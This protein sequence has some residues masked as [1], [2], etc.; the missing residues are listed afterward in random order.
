[1]AVDLQTNLRNLT[2]TGNQQTLLGA[3]GVEPHRLLDI[4]LQDVDLPRA[5]EAGAWVLTMHADNPVGGAIGVAQVD[6]TITM[7]S[8]GQAIV[9]NVSVM[10]GTVLQ[11]P[12]LAISVDVALTQVGSV[13][14]RVSAMLKPGFTDTHAQLLQAFSIDNATTP[15]RGFLPNFARRVQVNGRH[16]RR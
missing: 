1:M 8:G 11:V 9:F 5:W 6:A 7:G 3:R 4:N 14:M 2:R 16:R 12:A 10:P 15:Q 13:D